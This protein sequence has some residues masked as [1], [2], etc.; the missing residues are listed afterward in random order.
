MYTRR[1]FLR[2]NWRKDF[3]NRSTFAEVIIKHQVAYFFE[4]QCAEGHGLSAT[5][6]L[7]VVKNLRYCYVWQSWK[8]MPNECRRD[9]SDRQRV[10]GVAATKAAPPSYPDRRRHHR[11]HYQQQQQQQPQVLDDCRPSST[12]LRTL[13]R[14]SLTESVWNLGRVT[15]AAAVHALRHSTDRVRTS[16]VIQ[17]P[18]DWS[19]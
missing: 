3:E 7:L 15:R 4:T 16:Q 1:I 12:P 10:G 9:A 5:A 18:T 11:H 19:S 8:A 17:A 2:I 13:D 6:E 14:V